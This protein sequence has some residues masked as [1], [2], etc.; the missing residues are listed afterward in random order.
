MGIT[1]RED[2][3]VAFLQY[4]D[5]E[6]ICQLAQ[7]LMFDK[8]GLERIVSE[9]SCDENFKKLNG[10]PDKWRK[11]WKLVAGELQHFG[12]D[13]F[14]NLFRGKGVLYKEILSD[15]CDKLSV[16]YKK[17]STAYDIE[18]LLIE[19]LTEMSW[20]K[21]SPEEKEKVLD[22]MNIPD[23]LTGT[24]LAFI[25][26]SIKTGGVG[27]LQWSSWIAQS[28]SLAFGQAA[29]TRVGLGA[30]AAFV[31]SR[32]AAVFA[33]PLAAIIVTV[34]LLSGA[35]YRVTM[36]SVIQIAYMRRKYEQ[37]DRF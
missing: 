11:S 33:G 35:A 5:E 36:P 21:L 13:S 28:A 14:V 22:T 37:K 19:K 10:Q 4:C 9:I 7:Y 1:F 23:V 30:A 27:S 24:P 8:D 16:K 17:E 32:G 2:D 18:N 25:L 26:S 3:D 29:L 12:G 20:E 15:V 31:G 34:P 6:D